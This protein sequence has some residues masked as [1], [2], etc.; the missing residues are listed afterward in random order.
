MYAYC[1]AGLLK[2]GIMQALPLYGIFAILLFVM[3]M[4]LT[5]VDTKNMGQ[6]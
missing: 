4:F 2:L 1:I 6:N 3:T 5:V